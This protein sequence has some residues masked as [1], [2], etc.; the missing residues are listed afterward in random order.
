MET[1]H[2]PKKGTNKKIHK[3]KI[4]AVSFY[5]KS[6]W[7]LTVGEHRDLSIVHEEGILGT[8]LMAGG[9]CLMNSERLMFGS[10]GIATVNPC[11]SLY[12][13]SIQHIIN[14]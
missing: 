10:V 1:L 12:F 6:G 2:M 13:L 9:D 3:L 11:I 5:P 14:N 7:R 8:V 4:M